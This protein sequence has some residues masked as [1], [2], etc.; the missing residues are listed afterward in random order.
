MV[1]ESRKRIL[2][3]EA[4]EL[5][6]RESV[7]LHTRDSNVH[8]NT[9]LNFSKEFQQSWKYLDLHAKASSSSILKVEIVNAYGFLRRWN[10]SKKIHKG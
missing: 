5:Y 4:V 9:L 2:T 3:R 10:L 1:G 8:L 7:N 6:I